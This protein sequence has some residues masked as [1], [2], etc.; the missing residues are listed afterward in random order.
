MEQSRPD[1]ASARRDG[2]GRGALIAGLL[3]YL[4]LLGAAW[5][6]LGKFI[7]GNIS[8]HL[9]GKTLQLKSLY[10]RL[11]GDA[12]LVFLILPAALW[13]EALVVGWRDSSARQMLRAPTA[14]TRTDLA[15]FAVSQAHLM[16][17]VGRLMTL[18]ATMIS[19]AAIHDWLAAAMGVSI[20]LAGLPLLLQIVI[21]FYISTFFDYW[22]HRLD[23][24]SLFWPLHRYHH[25]A[26]DFCVITAARSHPAAFT[27][28]F[29]ITLPMAVLGASP[30]VMVTVNVMVIALG[31]LI[32]SKIDSNFGWV[33]RYIIQSP[34]HHRLH[35]QL[36]Y[37]TTPTGHF[38]MAPV[39]DHLFGTWRGECDQTLVIGVDTPY[40]HGFWLAPDL[41]RDYADFWKGWALL[42]ARL[43][44]RPSPNRS[45]AGAA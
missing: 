8:L 37:I 38:G 28:I 9:L 14:S 21:Y 3:V 20:S 31:F 41:V 32:H 19:G 11:A 39:W 36:D 44:G 30:L 7:P 10:N 12:A 5:W 15:F 1:M 23:H 24:S 17:I 43:L 35:H 2:A 40:R 16:G 33:G 34:Q 22:T 29:F 45:A 25:A 42:A 6:G 13:I 18:G 27:A 4:V 26:R